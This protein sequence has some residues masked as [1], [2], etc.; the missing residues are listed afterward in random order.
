MHCAI[1]CHILAMNRRK[2]RSF[3]FCIKQREI[4]SI[5]AGVEIIVVIPVIS[6]PV[7]DD[8]QSI[9]RIDLAQVDTYPW[10]ISI[11]SAIPIC[12][13]VAIDDLRSGIDRIDAD[14][15]DLLARRMD[16]SEAIGRIKD[17]SGLTVLQT[18]RWNSVLER[19]RALAKEKDLDE[20]FITEIYTTI[21]RA[22]MERQLKR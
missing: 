21:H 18:G 20:D 11:H 9:K 8:I 17:S 2:L 4:L 5:H 19:V 3:I 12:R 10:F 7:S 13:A 16:I 1:H 22:S 6:C 15:I 14:L